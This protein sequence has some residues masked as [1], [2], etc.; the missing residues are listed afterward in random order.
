ME[1]APCYYC[2]TTEGEHEL[3]PNQGARRYSHIFYSFTREPAI[4]H[5]YTGAVMR[6]LTVEQYLNGTD[7]HSTNH[8]GSIQQV[9]C[10]HHR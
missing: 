3:H 7:Q 2:S 9:S 8:K 10:H 1:P 4:I 5:L 6:E